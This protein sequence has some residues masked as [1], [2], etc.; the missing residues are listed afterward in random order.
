MSESAARA[1]RTDVR[2]AAVESPADVAVVARLAHEIWYEHYVP[3]IGRVQVDYM[4][5]RFQS[6]TAIA[7]QQA[8]GLRYYLLRCD[9]TAVGYFAIEPQPAAARMFLSKLYLLK[10]WRGH[11]IGQQAMAFIEAECRRECLPTLSLTVNK[12][13]PA[14]LA[15]ERLGFVNVADVVTDIGAGFVM[16]D[17]RMEKTITTGE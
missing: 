9:E 12:F 7:G 6:A 4:V 15:Y 2:I 1:T 10:A 17:Y 16:D 13:N 3:I 8:K 5:P 14:A 11:G